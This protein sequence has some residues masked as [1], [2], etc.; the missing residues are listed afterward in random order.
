[1]L[2]YFTYLLYLF[3]LL[4][5]HRASTF[6]K[7][8]RPGW[9]TGAGA[10]AG[11]GA[12]LCLL[13]LL[14]YFT[15]FTYWHPNGQVRSIKKTDRAGSLGLG[16]GWGWSSIM[17]TYVTYLLYLL[18]LLS[19]HRASTFGKENRPGWIPGAGAGAGAGAPL[20]LL[21]LPTYFTYFT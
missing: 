14:T 9:I 21:T 2:T 13:T 18:Y 12:T 1:M 7:E 11:A 15:C 4:G 20:C 19:P 16:L 5:P 8:N 6:G 10:G 17:L 3:Y